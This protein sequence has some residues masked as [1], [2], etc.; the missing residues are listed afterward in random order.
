MKGSGF[1]IINGSPRARGRSSSV[2]ALLSARLKE[3]YPAEP[4]EVF[5]VSDSP[6]RGCIG[7]AYCE[8]SGTCVFQDEMSGLIEKLMT[9]R[10]A[11]VISPIYFS[12]VPSQMKAVLD[13][14]QPL[15]YRR[16]RVIRAG[17]GLPPKRPLGL[18]LVGEGGDPH[19]HDA[20]VSVCRSAFNLADLSVS[21][22]QAFI[23]GDQPRRPDE[24]WLPD[25]P[26]A[27]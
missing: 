12:G 16:M 14:L 25:L 1:L 17:Q 19:G 4:I 9:V 20:A 15:F 21:N 11:F 3:A 2:E 8:G 26:G 10:A 5:R 18:Y 7:C 23:G 27:V 13:R 22:V 6:V 24:L